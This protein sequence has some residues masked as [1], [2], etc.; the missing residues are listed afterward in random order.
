MSVPVA[1]FLSVHVRLTPTCVVQA[2][3]GRPSRRRVVWHFLLPRY[4][5]LP[6]CCVL[7]DCGGLTALL[8]LQRCKARPL[9]PDSSVPPCWSLL[10]L[11]FCTVVCSSF[12]A[13][14]GRPVSHVVHFCSWCVSVCVCVCV[15][16]CFA[17]ASLV[18]A[19]RRDVPRSLTHSEQ[20]GI[21]CSSEVHQCECTYKRMKT[22]NHSAPKPLNVRVQPST[23][24]TSGITVCGTVCTYCCSAVSDCFVSG[25]ERAVDVSG[26]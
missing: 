21:P 20:W 11:S 9:S 8:P 7:H 1:V 26:V 16:L 17:G 22:L 10:A 19:S 12:T 25:A 2:Y 6:L 23:C 4:V 3:A 24:R 5:L 14:V 15:C 13:F 18:H